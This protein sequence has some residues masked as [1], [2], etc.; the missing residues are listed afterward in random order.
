M[1]GQNEGLYIMYRSNR[2]EAEVC[3]VIS[4]GH[5][6]ILSRCRCEVSYTWRD[7]RV[8]VKEEDDV[9]SCACLGFERVACFMQWL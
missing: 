1:L 2:I 8:A 6:S 5:V 7:E 3:E 9:G 4:R